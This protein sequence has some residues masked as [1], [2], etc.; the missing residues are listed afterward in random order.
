MNG[1][2]FQIPLNPC[3]DATNAILYLILQVF[4]KN[5]KDP[6]L[7]EIPSTS[8]T[9]KFIE[10]LVLMQQIHFFSYFRITA[11]KHSG[12]FQMI[13]SNIVTKS[14]LSSLSV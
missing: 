14:K 3:F 4:C 11:S 10:I 5:K 6:T 8:D 9:L 1:A 13:S 2:N 7:F 12:N